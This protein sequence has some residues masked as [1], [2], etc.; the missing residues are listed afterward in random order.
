[1]VD[2]RPLAAMFNP[3]TPPEA[4]HLILAS[5]MVCGFSVASVYAV[6]LLRGRRDAYVKRGFAIPF[7]FAAV[8]APIQVIVGDWAG[9]RVADTQPVKLAA[10]EG[11]TRTRTG[12][13]FTLGGFYDERR[14]EVRYGIE[15]PRLLSLLAYHDPNARVVG[16]ETVPARDRPPVNVVRFAFQTMVSIGSALAL[17]G[18]LFLLTWLRARRLPRSPWFYRA[19][20]AAGPLALVALIAGWITTEVGR[21]P[22]IVYG[23]MRTSQAVT[24][25]NGLRVGL[26][27]LIVLYA[28]LALAVAWLL[29]RLASRPP[30]TELGAPV[31][32]G[33]AARGGAR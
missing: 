14:G 11:V 5:F 22:W 32:A 33:A 20:V 2:V 9:R 8:T 28:T 21:Q 15:I 1:V 12:A 3:A 17:L 18:A 31:R 27:F 16:L 19:V 10:L 4:V 13:P 24:D 26:V 30:E 6:G 7:T 23:V 25:A 29:R